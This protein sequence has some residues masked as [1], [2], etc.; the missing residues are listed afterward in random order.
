MPTKEEMKKFTSHIEQIVREKEL[1]HIE[2]IVYYCE[3]IGMEI[4]LASKMIEKPLKSKLSRTATDLNLVKK[5][6][7]LPI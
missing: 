7:R 5:S 1:N 2:A 6:R 4:E 3:K